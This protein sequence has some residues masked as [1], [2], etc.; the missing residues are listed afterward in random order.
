MP[1]ESHK[2]L[3][4]RERQII[5]V[6]YQHTEASAQKVRAALSD[7][8]SYSAVRALLARMVDKD[9]VS[10]RMEAG[11]YVYF[12]KASKTEAQQTALQRLLKTF[13]D[14]SAAKAVSALLG[15]QGNDLTAEEL[16]LL[17]AEIKK[18]KRKTKM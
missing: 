9:L 4:R 3:S 14:G 6:L 11:K 8:P 1:P 15:S 7:P 2:D 13:F 17:E 5:D 10:F 18:A 12:V 16:A